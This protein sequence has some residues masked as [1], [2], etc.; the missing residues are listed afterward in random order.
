MRWCCAILAIHHQEM[1]EG[2]YH[3]GK[4]VI[5]SK[6]AKAIKRRRDTLKLTPEAREVRNLARFRDLVS[7]PRKMSPWYRCEIEKNRIDPATIRSEDSP[8]LTSA[9]VKGHLDEIVTDHAITGAR[10]RP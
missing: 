9:M 7:F 4:E 8:V 1:D 10:S 6:L 5:L 3:Q 2:T